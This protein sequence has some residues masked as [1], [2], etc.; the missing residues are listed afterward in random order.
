MNGH[1]QPLLVAVSSTLLSFSCICRQ[2]NKKYSY[3]KSKTLTPTRVGVCISPTRV[4]P[5]RF[6]GARILACLWCHVGLGWCVG[7]HPVAHTSVSPHGGAG[8]WAF[9]SSPTHQFSVTHKGWCVGICHLAH[10]PVSSPTP[11]LLVAICFA[12]HMATALV[13][14]IRR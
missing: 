7:I 1:Y 10:T 5:R 12:A 4:D 11:K 6:V 13:C 9:S 8:V 3:K 2:S 14:F